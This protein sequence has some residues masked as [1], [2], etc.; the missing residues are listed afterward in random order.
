MAT[1]LK[2]INMVSRAA[3]EFLDEELK[4]RG[5]GVKG[6]HTKYLLAVCNNAGISQDKLAKEV[7][8]N[9][10]NVARRLAALEESGYIVRRECE[11]D[12]RSLLVYP[13]EKA[14]ELLPVMRAI[15]A[16]W[17]EEITRG[18]TESEKAELL[19]L[20]DRL[21]ENAVRFFGGGR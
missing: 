20:T 14:M 3:T 9:K 2:N 7:F 16:Q 12:A 1:F 5:C 11:S 10:S 17:R 13:T 19:T 8:V 18:F 6:C 21:Y 4:K 15:N